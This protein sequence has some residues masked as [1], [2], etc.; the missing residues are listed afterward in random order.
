MFNS[1]FKTS[2]IIMHNILKW[3]AFLTIGIISLTCKLSAQTL[4]PA[5]NSATVCA[6]MQFKLTF[7]AAP[8]LQSS[9]KVRL[10]ESTGTL[11]STI[12]LS[13]MPAGTPMSA[14]WPWTETLNDTEIRVIRA[15]VEGKTA[16]FSFPVNSMEYGK[17]Y[18]VTVDKTVFSNAAT[19]GFNG[20]ATSQWAFKVKSKPA[21][22]LNYIVSADGSGDFATLQGALNFIPSGNNTAVK[23]FIKNGI[24]TGLAFIKN[25]NKITIEGESADGVVI[26]AFNNSSLNASTHWRS[27]VN[28]QGNDLYFT[29]MTFINTTPNGGT[30]AEAV[31]ISGERV[32]IVNCKFFSY[33]DTQLLD[34]KVYLKDC[35]IEGDVDFIWGT[36]TV[37]FQ[38]CE[39]RAN[40]NGG[41]NVMARNDNTRHGYAFAD[42]KLTRKSTATTTQYLGRDAGASYPNAEIVYLNCSFDSHIPA[43]GWQINSS[44]DASEIIFAEYRSVNMSGNL[45]NTSSRHAKSK[46]LTSAQATQYRD[47]N[48]FF[49]GWTPVFPAT[50]PVVTITAPAE[51]T[52]FKA[53]AVI[54]LTATASTVNNLT[55]LD[56]YNGT[57][58]T[59]KGVASGNTF[60]FNW[61]N[62]AVGTYSITAK[63]TYSDGMVVTSGNV[64][65]KVLDC[66]GVENGTAKPDICD[67]C[68]GG[69]TGKTACVGSAEAEEAACVFDGTIDND[70]PGFKGSG[71]INVPNEAGSKISFYINAASAG[72]KTVSFRYANGSANDRSA[73]ITVNGISIS[74]VL[75]FPNTGTFSDYKVAEVTL[76]LSQ[77]LNIIELA[78][79]TAEGLANID[80][81]GFVSAGLVKGECLI[82]G[83][84]DP[85]TETWG[86]FPNPFKGN[87]NINVAGHFTFDLYDIAGEKVDSGWGENSVQAGENLNQ[88]FYLLKIHKDGLS[89]IVKIVKE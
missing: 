58:L 39:L 5:N 61:N 29:G 46:Q 57:T 71:F 48:W 81:I 54:N 65:I 12:D 40:D 59:G 62:V 72:L 74:P 73:N 50:T 53:P 84:E 24:Y 47:L 42:C 51:N 4:L 75:S 16:I 67:R 55:G 37:F 13:A 44:I 60:T 30:Q 1:D 22:D 83:S 28:I 3:I 32:I 25:R 79:F 64:S 33:Q 88:G 80:Q 2:S 36:G 43:V 86:A 8:V 89:K 7:S 20:I 15:L 66:A 52:T 14:T 41:Y 35:L 85:H 63:A 77:G 10:Y 68:V 34:G 6:D 31:K 18:Y 26:K 49:N 82:T 11:I 21:A 45:I 76:T 70:N 38:S 87:L 19:L 56:F 23:I 78:A 69:T 27:V 9:G 17:S